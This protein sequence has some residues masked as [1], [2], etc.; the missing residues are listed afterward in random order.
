MV[1]GA[2]SAA[3]TGEL[4]HCEKSINALKYRRILQ[5]GL[6]P[7]IEKSF[8][9][10][11][12]SDVIYLQDNVPAHTANATKT[13][14]ENK[15]ISLIFWPGQSPHLNPIENIYFIYLFNSCL[16]PDQRFVVKTIKSLIFSHFWLGPNFHTCSRTRAHTNTHTVHIL[17][18]R[19]HTN[20]LYTCAHTHVLTHSHTLM[21][22]H[23][24]THTVHILYTCAC[25]HTQTHILYT[26]CTHAHA[27]THT[28]I[29]T[30]E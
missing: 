28:Y 24:N 29:H 27:R 1:W 7:T 19:A 8:S 6:L 21:H 23:T 20:T 25:T 5:K 2:F 26:Y 4:L 22:M 15:S 18:T 9:K 12:Q 14:L 16:F 3:G 17:Y 10:E 11:E 30:Q 13:W